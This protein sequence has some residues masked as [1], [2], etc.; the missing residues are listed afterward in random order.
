MPHA[1]CRWF[2]AK[3]GLLVALVFGTTTGVQN[4]SHDIFAFKGG[5]DFMHHFKLSLLIVVCAFC[6]TLEAVETKEKILMGIV[7]NHTRVFGVDDLY[8]ANLDFAPWL[9]MTKEAEAFVK[10]HAKGDKS[11][12]IALNRVLAQNDDLIT[13]MTTARA[14]AVGGLQPQ[15]REKFLATF[16]SIAAQSKETE[17]TLKRMSLALASKKEA[18]DVLS[19]LAMFVGTT[20]TAASNHLIKKLDTAPKKALPPTPAKPAR[21]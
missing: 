10:E 17:N 5:F 3:I 21:T 11:I 9:A 4:T 7:S 2:G 12:L 18:R 8:K 19:Q 16:K 20:A 15:A 13:T 14:Q 6:V 1:N